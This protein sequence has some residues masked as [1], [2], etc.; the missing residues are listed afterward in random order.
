MHGQ[1]IGVAECVMIMEMES[2]LVLFLSQ[3]KEKRKRFHHS[4][5]L[6]YFARKTKNI[7]CLRAFFFLCLFSI[8]QA[9]LFFSPFLLFYKS[10]W[11]SFFCYLRGETHLHSDNECC[12]CPSKLLQQA[13][14]GLGPVPVSYY[15]SQPDS[16][17][18]QHTNVYAGDKHLIEVKVKANSKISWRY[19][20]EE[21]DIGFAVYFDKTDKANDLTTM[22]PVFPYIRLECSK[23]PLSGSIV[24]ENTGRYIVEFD[25]YYSWLSAKQLHYSLSVEEPPPSAFEIVQQPHL[26]TAG[27]CVSH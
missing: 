14:D 5:I 10:S 18:E 12:R 22:E 1:D 27:L 21:D 11:T 17:F 9:F 13:R 4:L 20:T 26:A 23:V 25:N 2:K 16:A 7:N 8:L 24:C 6:N 3:K 19:M 15:Y